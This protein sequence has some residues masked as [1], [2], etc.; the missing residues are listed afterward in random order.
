MYGCTDY[1]PFP[2]IFLAVISLVG[3]TRKGGRIRTSVHGPVRGNQSLEGRF[4]RPIVLP[5]VNKLP[6]ILHPCGCAR[7][8]TPGGYQSLEGRFSR[9][10]VLRY[11][12]V[13]RGFALTVFLLIAPS[14]KRR[15]RV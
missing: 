12:I 3:K 2:V 13:N 7:E 15:A 6:E 5:V 8:E 4:S 10:I 11:V 1:P 14:R 9:P